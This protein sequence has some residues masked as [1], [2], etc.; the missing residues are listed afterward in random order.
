[1]KYL[2][3]YSN[4]TSLQANV[5]VPNEDRIALET[6]RREKLSCVGETWKP[7]WG[8]VPVWEGDIEFSQDEMDLLCICIFDP[9]IHTIV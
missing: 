4:E 5:S 6:L 2:S 9:K 3:H 1:M 8:Y 7:K